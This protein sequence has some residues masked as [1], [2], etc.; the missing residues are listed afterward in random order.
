MLERDS[1]MTCLP[2]WPRS[3]AASAA[4]A[5]SEGGRP[6]RKRAVSSGLPLGLANVTFDV[7]VNAATRAPMIVAI[8]R[9][10]AMRLIQLRS[11]P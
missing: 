5:L 9:V 3:R 1:V 2:L 7:N 10:L 8:S 6:A 4:A 11:L